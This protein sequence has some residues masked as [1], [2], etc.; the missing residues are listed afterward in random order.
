M[1]ASL[2]YQDDQEPQV[3]LDHLAQ[4]DLQV[5]GVSQEKMVPQ[6]PEAHQDQRVPQE[7]QELLAQVENQGNQEIV[8]HQVHLE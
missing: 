1:L 2:D 7:F 8:G 5:K 6:V 4:W 3:Y